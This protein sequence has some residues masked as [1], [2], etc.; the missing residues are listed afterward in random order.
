MR[1]LPQWWEVGGSEGEAGQGHHSRIGEQ[2]QVHD[3]EL[4]KIVDVRMW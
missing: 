3:T 2:L 4:H 1:G